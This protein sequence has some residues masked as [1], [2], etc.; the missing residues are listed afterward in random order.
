MTDP[1]VTH[2]SFIPV[3]KPWTLVKVG[4]TT[5]DLFA[6]GI[7][8]KAIVDRLRR[9]TMRFEPEMNRESL[10]ALFKVWAEANPLAHGKHEARRQV[11]RVQNRASYE[12]ARHRLTGPDSPPKPTTPRKCITGCGRTFKSEGAHHR[13]CKPCRHHTYY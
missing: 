10:R 9:D 5:S 12:R 2:V 3:L 8:P 11:Q 1:V 13:M 7:S 6:M 4:L